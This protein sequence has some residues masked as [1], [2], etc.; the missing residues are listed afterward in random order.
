VAWLAIELAPGDARRRVAV[1]RGETGAQTDQESRSAG[2][3]AAPIMTVMDITIHATFLPRDDPDAS[4]AFYRDT[5]GLRSAKTLSTPRA[6]GLSISPGFAFVF[7]SAR[8][9]GSR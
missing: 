8:H 3:R 7:R 9:S 4:L 5:L 1:A 2:H 6:I